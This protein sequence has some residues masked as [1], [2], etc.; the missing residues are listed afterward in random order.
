MVK[1]NA[2]LED[3]A[4]GWAKELVLKCKNM[5]PPSDSGLTD[6]GFNIA[7]KQGH[8]DFQTPV[9]VMKLWE[10][11]ILQRMA[12]QQGNDSGAV[13]SHRVRRM[14]PSRVRRR[15]EQDLYR[16]GLF[17]REGGKLRNGQR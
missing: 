7:M 8:S 17:L 2:D 13:E 11:K 14:R 3:K 5:N 6:Y 10:K 4:E 12:G 15:C 16:R 9:D 1:R